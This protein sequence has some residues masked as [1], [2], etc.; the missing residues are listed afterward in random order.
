MSNDT[1]LEKPLT[2]PEKVFVTA[3]AQGESQASAIRKAYPHLTETSTPNYLYKKAS[4][5]VR[6]GKI[7]LELNQQ[8]AMMD[9]IASKAHGRLAQ[10]VDSNRES[11]AL[12][13]TKF[14]IEQSHG[15]ATQRIE[16]RTQLVSVTYDLSGGQAPPVPQEI[17]DQLAEAK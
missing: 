6:K 12:D 9:E 1:K 17:L 2:Y 16:Q 8:R 11:V 15:K 13:A 14:A 3:I 4:T 7:I 10:L 5:L